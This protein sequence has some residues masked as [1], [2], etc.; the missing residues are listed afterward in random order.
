MGRE[1]QMAVLREIRANNPISR[2][3]IATNTGLS[4]PSVARAVEQ[5]LNEELI[6]KKVLRALTPSRAGNREDLCSM[7]EQGSFKV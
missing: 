4:K 7:R 1:N 2:A 3:Q 5:L 6:L